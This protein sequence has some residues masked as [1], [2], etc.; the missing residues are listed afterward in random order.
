MWGDG[1]A[2]PRR[3]RRQADEMKVVVLVPAHNEEDSIGATLDSLRE[4]TVAPDGIYV[5]IDNCTDETA[6]RAISAGVSVHATV[7]NVAKKAGALNQGLAHVMPMLGPEDCLLLVDADS[8]LCP[9]WIEEGVAAL[10]REPSVGAVS[11]AYIARKGKGLVTL[12]QRAEYAQER[13]RIS[14]RDG[15]VDVLSG[16]ATLVPVQI[17]R[18]LVEARGYAYDETALTEDFEI[19]LAIKALGYNPRCYQQLRVV[20]DVM[21]TWGDLARQRIRWQRGTIETLQSYGWTGRTRRL[22]LTQG[23]AY[24]STLVTL[25]LVTAW[26]CTIALGAEP[27]LRWLVILPVYVVEQA[28]AT[29]KAGW[30]PTLVAG[31]LVPMWV[32]D[33][34]RVSMY[35]IALTRSLRRTDAVWG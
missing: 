3:E 9:G 11:G 32:Y 2:E 35:W 15:R 20:T 12:L 27:D 8:V 17:L 6:A 7:G 21:E 5:V 25:M 33:T 24:A 30:A 22:W 28:V 23:L 4:Q 1:Q 18:Q 31:L 14:R 34:F 16:T 26:T 29:H 13:R 10:R 19:T